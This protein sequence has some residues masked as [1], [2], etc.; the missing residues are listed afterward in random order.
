VNDAKGWKRR[1]PELQRQ[2]NAQEARFDAGARLWAELELSDVHGSTGAELEL[3][4][5]RAPGP[6]L[7]SFE[8]APSGR[9]VRRAGLHR[10]EVVLPARA[11]GPIY[12]ASLNATAPPQARWLPS[13]PQ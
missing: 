1:E 11:T 6:E 8:A 9:A 5:A 2:R 13:S 7:E 10:A 4:D 3:T 12:S